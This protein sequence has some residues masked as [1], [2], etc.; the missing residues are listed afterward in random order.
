ML[1]KKDLL[2]KHVKDVKLRKG[3]TVRQ[4]VDAQRSIGGFSAQH[5]IGGIDILKEMLDDKDSFNFLSFPADIVSTGLR[6][7]IADSVRYFDAIITTGGTLDHDLA[8][9]Y[10]GKY[11]IGTFE[12]DDAKLKKLDIYRLGNIFIG[13]DQYGLAVEKYFTEIMTDLYNSP[14]YKGEY[15]ASELAWEFGK[16]IKDESSILRQ[17]YLHNVRIYNPGILDGAFGTQLTLFSQDHKFKLNLIKDELALSNI[18]FDNKT[19]GALMLG[20][21]I[22]KHHVIWWNQFKGGLDYA[23][24]VTTASQ[25][26][27]SLSGARLTEAVSWGKVKEKAHYT[28]IDGDMTIILP[29]MFSYLEL[30]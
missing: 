24:Y 13:S 27:G 10:G 20:G 15:S 23:V 2:K 8:K 4:L 1:S 14:D 16:R 3:M 26:D 30:F 18:S 5:M 7:M 22:S 29:I 6:G 12:V 17:A 11:S 25:Y 9:A 19:T 28:T 21:G